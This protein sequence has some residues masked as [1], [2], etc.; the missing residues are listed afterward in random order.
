M[1]DEYR[2]MA[3]ALVC[4]TTIVLMLIATTSSCSVQQY[5]ACLEFRGKSKIR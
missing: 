4:G 5:K 3:V 1:S 2:V